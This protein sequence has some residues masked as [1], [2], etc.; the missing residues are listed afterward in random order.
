VTYA[1][2][3][4]QT[5][6]GP[7]MLA[8][9][10]WRDNQAAMKAK[11]EKTALK[12]L[13]RIFGAVFTIS[14][15]K[16]FAAM[17]MRDLSAESGLS[18]GALYDYVGSKEGL[19]TMLQAAGRGLAGEVLERAVAGASDPWEQLKLVITHHLYMS[20]ALPQWFYFSYMEARH[21]GDREKKAALAAEERS[22]STLA[23]IL[24]Q[25]VAQ[26]RFYPVDARLLAAVGKAML[27]EW[28]VKRG[29]YARRRVAVEDYAAFLIEL[30]ESRLRPARIMERKDDHAA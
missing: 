12:N 1:Q 25:G 17:T 7:D 2:F 13:S 15:Q 6:V 30:F 19:L 29:K 14:G 28:Y 3:L 23:A 26:G 20:E 10:A 4:E 11:K 9:Q 5:G 21:L 27:Q 18:A 16:G 22:E 8:R 24:E